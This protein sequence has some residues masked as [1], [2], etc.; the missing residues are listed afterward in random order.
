M[1]QTLKEQHQRLEQLLRSA[2][3]RTLSYG[4]IKAAGVKSPGQL[5]YELEL[6]GWELEHFPGG[7]RLRREPRQSGKLRKRGDR[8]S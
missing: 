4:A 5:L 2:G 1:S 6:A 7:V 3:D 8:R